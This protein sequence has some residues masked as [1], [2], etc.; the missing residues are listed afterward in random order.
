MAAISALLIIFADT[1]APKSVPI[2][3]GLTPQE[4]MDRAVA[5]ADAQYESPAE[6]MFES[7]AISTIKSLDGD[8]HVTKT[9]STRRRQYPLS[10]ALFDELI[11]KNGRPLSEKE[12]RDEEKRKREFIREVEER[13]SRGEHPQ[14]E[15][16]SISAPGA[17]RSLL[18]TPPS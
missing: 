11:E 6:A 8:G 1:P 4:I 5:R 3:H 17:P 18:V 13:T 14:P 9:E 16:E 10:G 15:S 7:E 2:D 12:L